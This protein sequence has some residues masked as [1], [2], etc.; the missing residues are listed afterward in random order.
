MSVCF[1]AL[2][3][4]RYSANGFAHFFLSLGRCWLQIWMLSW[5]AVVKDGLPDLCHLHLFFLFDEPLETVKF[6]GVDVVKTGSAEL[7]V[8]ILPKIPLFLS[9]LQLRHCGLEG[10]D[11]CLRFVD[12]ARNNFPEMLWIILVYFVRLKLEN[13]RTVARWQT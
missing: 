1:G 10:F 8:V 13:F 7:Q 9:F 6:V 12:Q 5:F 3:V 2:F 4:E 11:N